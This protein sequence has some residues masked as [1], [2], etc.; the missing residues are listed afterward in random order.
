MIGV[1]A[2]VN[3][4]RHLKYVDDAR[5][6][7]LIKRRIEGERLIACLLLDG[8]KTAEAA[9]FDK[10]ISFFTMAWHD[11]SAKQIDGAA[12]ARL[13]EGIREIC[14]A[15]SAGCFKDCV[16]TLEDACG[17]SCNSGNRRL[18]SGAD[19]KSA[20]DFAARH[21]SPPPAARGTVD[22]EREKK[23]NRALYFLGDAHRP[24]GSE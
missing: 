23:D 14:L 19:R 17:G 4:K 7:E 9:N 6:L 21:T 16:G 15:L 18:S 3:G 2:F 12:R 10:F 8:D 22:E 20:G 5:L 24:R 13:H 11:F 1:D